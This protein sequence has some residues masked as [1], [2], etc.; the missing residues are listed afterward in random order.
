MVDINGIC[1]TFDIK[2]NYF[3]KKG[4]ELKC[5]EKS[6]KKAIKIQKICVSTKMKN[7]YIAMT[8]SRGNG[9]FEE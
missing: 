1:G 7:Y 5:F 6:D 9:I 3:G 4:K 8:K 2:S